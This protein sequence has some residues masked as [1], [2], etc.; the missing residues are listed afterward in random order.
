MSVSEHLKPLVEQLLAAA[1]MSGDRNDVLAVVDSLST[2]GSLIMAKME[3]I[4]GAARTAKIVATA[5]AICALCAGDIA[6][7]YEPK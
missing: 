2:G 7:E 6:G 5:Y 3:P 1:D 4:Y